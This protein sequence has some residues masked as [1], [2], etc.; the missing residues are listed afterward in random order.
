[1]EPRLEMPAVA[2]PKMRSRAGATASPYCGRTSVTA[3]A[4]NRAARPEKDRVEHQEW[5]QRFLEKIRRGRGA[6]RFADCT[7]DVRKHDRPH[8]PRARCCHSR[9][10][11][12]EAVVA[13]EH[14]AAVSGHDQP[15]YRHQGHRHPDREAERDADVQHAPRDLGGEG[16]AAGAPDGGAAGAKATIASAKPAERSDP[17]PSEAPA[18][19]LSA[20][21]N[22]A[23]VVSR[24]AK[25]RRL[26]VE[27]M[28]ASP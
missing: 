23:L 6:P 14:G 12:R 5:G 10:G 9:D 15:V 28:Y 1:M 8:H 21:C 22:A 11:D 7:V 26:P 3:G 2:P 4:M 16:T 13:K 17:A 27:R 19:W 25:L 24:M 20:R 18:G